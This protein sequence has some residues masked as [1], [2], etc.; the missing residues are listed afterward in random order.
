[1]STERPLPQTTRIIARCA[2]CK[3]QWSGPQSP[4]A[5]QRHA[6]KTGHPVEMITR[7]QARVKPSDGPQQ[8]L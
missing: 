8:Q 3:F 7:T 4:V 5:A 6:N 2:V 1:M